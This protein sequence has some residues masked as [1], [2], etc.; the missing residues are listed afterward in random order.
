MNPSLADFT[1]HF[2]TSILPARVGKPKDKSL[3]EGAVRIIY[4][5][6][7]ARLRH[8][9]FT[10]LAQLNV[11]IIEAVEVHNQTRFQRQ[12]FSRREAFE[13]YERATLPALPTT[14]FLLRH[15]RWA[16]VQKNCHVLLADDNRYYSV[17]YRLIGQR[18]QLVIS[19]QVLEVYHT[20]Q[21]VAG[22]QRLAGAGQYATI[23]QHL[24]PA[25][26]H[27]MNWTP[28]YFTEWA[29][30]IGPHTLTVMKR[31]LSARKH[32]E[33]A[34]RSCL[35]ILRQEKKVGAERL[36]RACERALH[37]NSVGYSVIVNILSRGLD[38]MPTS[39][40][41]PDVSVA[42]DNIRGAAAYQ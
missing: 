26:R 11:A 24:P 22:H 33:L 32:P 29:E 37:Y 7:Y 2:G 13:D 25:H 4:Q 42:H 18:V 34:H 17:P 23:K 15:Y 20:H 5:R 39:T 14:A 12:S 19:A 40:V 36:E 9:S 28:E 38:N 8:R 27:V 31:L 3:V 6:V 21:R 41:Q 35:G 10:S 30:R 1:L 16:T